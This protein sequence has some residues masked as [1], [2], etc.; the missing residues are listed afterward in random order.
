VEGNTLW[1]RKEGSVTPVRWRPEDAEDLL[2]YQR[3]GTPP[4]LVDGRLEP[5]MGLE[6]GEAMMASQ[7]PP[8]Q[9]P[10]AVADYGNFLGFQREDVDGDG[11]EEMV[12]HNRSTMWVYGGAGSEK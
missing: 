10:Y 1:M 5:V 12:F 11:V 3:P 9:D 4:T 2:L 7:K 8:K 6:A